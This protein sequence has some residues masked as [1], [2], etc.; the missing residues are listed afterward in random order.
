MN[1]KHI[2]G[3]FDDLLQEKGV[4]GEVDALANKRLLVLRLN[5][6][7]ENQGMDRQQLAKKA[8]VSES[9]LACL[10]DKNRLNLCL[11]TLGKVTTALGTM[12]SIGLEPQQSSNRQ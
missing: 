10:L 2:G 12:F 1:L 7:M 5:T 4:L 6:L 9:S 3:N 8:G 11:L